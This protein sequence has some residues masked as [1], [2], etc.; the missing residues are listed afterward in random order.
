MNSKWLTVLIVA[1]LLLGI[2]TGYAVHVTLAPARAGS[3]AEG[4]DLLPFAFLRLIRMIIAPLVFTTLVAGI[5]KMGDIA[6]IGRI[7]GQT[8]GLFMV[9]SVVSLVLGL[10]LVE[11][12]QPGRMTTLQLPPADAAS[13]VAAN[14]MTMRGFIEHL[15]PTSILDAMARNE[16]LQ[17]VV[18][19]L[20]FGTAMAALGERCRLLLDG[21]GA[22]AQVM[23]KVTGYVML[24]APLAVFGS[25][26]ATVAR[27]GL[28]IL[29][30][31]GAFIA[32][33][34]VGL[35]LLWLLIIGS[36]VALVG[37]R[38][39]RLIH[40][41]REPVLLAFSTASSE[42]AYPATLRALER[43][44]CSNRV[45]SFVLP[46]GYSFNLMGSMMYCSFALM[47]LAQLYG[48]HMGLG[49]QVTLML[50]LLLASKGMAGVPRAGL[51]VV[52]ATV[53]Q[54]GI[55][56]AGVLL[57]AGADHFLDMGRTATNVVGNSIA[58]A[59][60]AR[61]QGELASPVTSQPRTSERA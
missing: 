10:A 13:G 61:W 16:V 40:D 53:T 22:L 32:E 54:V 35:V 1:G 50:I 60:V 56:E 15:L 31:Y 38:A 25:L 33:F 45:A 26:A 58:T 4:A 34:Y 43:F 52:A 7:G 18:F 21:I 12:L 27:E 48:V 24:F 3:F 9:A 55:P 11:L 46:M 36:G 5:A 28:G 49:R 59:I 6:T 17:I 20:F 8:L 47:F 29:G 23:L 30:V 14:A 2:V 37:R 57:L 51:V 19:S 42:A 44:G 39:L 41:I